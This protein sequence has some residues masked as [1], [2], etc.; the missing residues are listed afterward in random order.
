MLL[1]DPHKSAFCPES[2]RSPHA[3]RCTLYVRAPSPVL[4]PVLAHSNPAVSIQRKDGRRGDAGSAFISHI[5]F[6]L[7]AELQFVPGKAGMN[8]AWILLK[9]A[10]AV[11]TS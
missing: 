10:A 6:L 11:K 5:C 8:R 2:C 7:I 4:A 3:L 1:G 9:R